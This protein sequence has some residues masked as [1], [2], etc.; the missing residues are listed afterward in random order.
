MIRA[1]TRIK[2]RKF[3]LAGVFLPIALFLTVSAGGIFAYSKFVDLEKE[4]V[5]VLST[6]KI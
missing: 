2:L 6:K 4:S 5:R 1:R 3:L